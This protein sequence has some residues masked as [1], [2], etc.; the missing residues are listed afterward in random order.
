MWAAKHLE[1]AAMW[2]QTP[3]ATT[4]GTAM[5]CSAQTAMLTTPQM[6][7]QMALQTTPQM[8][9]LPCLAGPIGAE[10]RLAGAL[11]A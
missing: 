8:A 1:R 5:C 6:T 2:V 7:P 11:A 9:A 4:S 3:A 10:G